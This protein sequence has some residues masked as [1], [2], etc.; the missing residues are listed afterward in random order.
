MLGRLA[1]MVH[2]RQQYRT[3][4]RAVVWLMALMIAMPVIIAS[5]VITDDGDYSTSVVILFNENGLSVVVRL[6]RPVSL[7]IDEEDAEYIMEH[8]GCSCQG[9][10]TLAG[11]YWQYPSE[12]DPNACFIRINR[13]TGDV[14]CFPG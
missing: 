10:L 4:K 6:D 7:P 8:S 3:N 12:L 11:D 9:Q 1:F 2:E 13:Y 14:D 5:C